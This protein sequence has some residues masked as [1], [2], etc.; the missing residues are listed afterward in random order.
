MQAFIVSVIAGCL[1]PIL[2]IVAEWGV[3]SSVKSDT[4]SVTGLVYAVAVGMVSRNQAVA[5]S[6]FFFATICAAIYGAEKAVIHG[7]EKY[8]ANVQEGM[9]FIEYG[10]V[11]SSGIILLFALMYSVERFARHYI[12]NEPFLEF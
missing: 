10:A 9:P 3:T 1:F 8:M 2:P 7:A 6:S 4:L 12:D 5:I 11:I